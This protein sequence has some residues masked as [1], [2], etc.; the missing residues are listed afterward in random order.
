[1]DVVISNDFDFMGKFCR[2]Y[3]QSYNDDK[4]CKL[5]EK[6]LWQG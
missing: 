6:T 5:K 4:L 3:H 1:M 2:D